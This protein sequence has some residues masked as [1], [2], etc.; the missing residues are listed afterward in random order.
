MLI[1]AGGSSNVTIT[2]PN[3]KKDTGTLFVL[4]WVTITELEINE[5]NNKAKVKVSSWGGG[6]K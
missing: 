1:G 3:G 2:Y 4:H 5:I 6:V